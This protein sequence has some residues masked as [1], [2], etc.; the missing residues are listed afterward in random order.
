MTYEVC[1]LLPKGCSFLPRP[2]STSPS[3]QILLPHV[4]SPLPRVQLLL[5]VYR[6][7][8]TWPWSII[9]PYVI[10]CGLITTLH[11]CVW[12]APSGDWSDTMVHLPAPVINTSLGGWSAIKSLVVF[13]I[14]VTCTARINGPAGTPH[15]NRISRKYCWKSMTWFGTWTPSD[16]WR[17]SRGQHIESGWNAWNWDENVFYIIVKIHPCPSRSLLVHEYRPI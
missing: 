3:Q 12:S 10:T 8:S 2:R 17:L 11:A 13:S 1:C 6:L 14:C 16:L 5:E 9:L 7:I 4:K 15:K